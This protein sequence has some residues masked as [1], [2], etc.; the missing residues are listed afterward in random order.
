MREINI[1]LWRNEELRDWS[2]E[3]DG[4]FHE[5]ISNEGLTDLVEG[6]LIIAAKSL[7]QSSV[8]GRELQCR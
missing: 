8:S 3:I 1:K 4:R 5:H 2:M 6:A 7:V